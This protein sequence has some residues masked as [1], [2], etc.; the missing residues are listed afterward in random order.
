MMMQPIYI[1]EDD[2]NLRELLCYALENAGFAVEGFPRAEEFYRRLKNGAPRLIL[3]DIMLPGEDGLSILAALR[4]LEA[5]KNLPVILL[6]AKG[7]E[8]DRIKGLDLGADDYVTKPFSVMEL[9]ARVRAVLRRAPE[10][11]RGDIVTGGALT[12]SAERHTVLADGEAVALTNKEFALLEC[13]L[14]NAGLA[15]TRDTLME[16]VWGFD[17]EG[18]SRTVDMHIRSLRQKLGKAG[19]AIKTVRG[20]GYKLEEDG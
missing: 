16:R 7:A 10:T 12:L 17:F 1:V 13:L 3:L 15:L 18:E 11:E 19:E 2:D 5:T 14:R 4:R 20:I 8:Y 6:T 9:V